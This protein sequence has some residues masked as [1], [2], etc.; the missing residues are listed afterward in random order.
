MA[1]RYRAQVTD[2]TCRVRF[3]TGAN[4][5]FDMYTGWLL[6]RRAQIHFAVSLN[7]CWILSSILFENNLSYVLFI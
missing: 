3:T 5:I 4:R 2:P 6:T 1:K 7:Y